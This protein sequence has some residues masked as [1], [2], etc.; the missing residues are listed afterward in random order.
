[1]GMGWEVYR[2]AGE[3]SEGSGIPK[4]KPEQT[5]IML[6]DCDVFLA[7]ELKTQRG[8]ET[9]TMFRTRVAHP[10]L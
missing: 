4:F 9:G 6:Q 10:L 5:G 8:E 3:D 1:M 7:T 2:E